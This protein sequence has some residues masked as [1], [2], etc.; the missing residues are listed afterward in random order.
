M[1]QDTQLVLHLWCGPLASQ[2]YDKPLLR[3]VLT[4]LQQKGLEP[5]G[6]ELDQASDE[7]LFTH[8]NKLIQDATQVWVL[9]VVQ[10]GAPTAM[11]RVRMLLEQLLK[12]RHKVQFCAEGQFAYNKMLAVLPRFVVAD[13]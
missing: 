4:A 2:P 12:H 8:A 7:V 11:P 3:Q 1:S 10:A 5:V 13:L 9:V 6:W